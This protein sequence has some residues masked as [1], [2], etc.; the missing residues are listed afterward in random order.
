MGTSF[1]KQWREGS[2][3]MLSRCFSRSYA[4]VIRSST[5]E[6]TD[7]ITLCE[8]FQE[9]L[10]ENEDLFSRRVSNQKITWIRC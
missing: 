5:A 1:L 8:Q 3:N 7:M 10:A 4:S 6:A 2:E 9:C